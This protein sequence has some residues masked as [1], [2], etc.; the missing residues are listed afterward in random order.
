MIS[1]VASTNKDLRSKIGDADE[2]LENVFGQ[3][4]GVASLLDVVRRHVDVVSTEMEVCSRYSP[5]NAKRIENEM[6]TAL[7]F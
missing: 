7:F 2:L 6:K 1:W 5:E 4:V 3:N